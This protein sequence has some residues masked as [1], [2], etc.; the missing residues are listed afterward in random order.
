MLSLNRIRGK[1]LRRK[2]ASVALDH[3]EQSALERTLDFNTKFDSILSKP[4]KAFFWPDYANPYQ[5]LFY[6]ADTAMFQSEPKTIEDAASY[7]RDNPDQ[8]VVFHL[9]WLNLLLKSGQDNKTD[10]LVAG[11][12]E[13]CTTFVELG[14]AVFWTVHNIEEHARAQVDQEKKLHA[15]LAKICAAIF[16]HGESASADL[17]AKIPSLSQRKIHVIPHG[18]YIGCYPDQSQRDEARDALKVSKTDHLFLT[19]GYVRKYK[20][21]DTLCDAFARLGHDSKAQLLIAGKVSSSDRTYFYDAFAR[22][23]TITCHDGFVPDGE[24][25]VYLNAADFAVFPYTAFTTSGAAVLAHSFSVP[26]IAPDVGF[27]REFVEDGQTGFLYDPNEQ[28]ALKDVIERAANLDPQALGR[29]RYNAFEHAKSLSWAKA[30]RRF[31]DALN[32]L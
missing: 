26:V 7:L 19:L 25:Q 24:V 4:T 3:R 17:V 15:F 20:G 5:Q 12:I 6:G 22:S 30:R 28:N 13:D 29:L 32:A 23:D 21:I 8:S 11:F 27:F 14:G 18:N 31:F 16:V 1:L 9:H 10:D 2:R